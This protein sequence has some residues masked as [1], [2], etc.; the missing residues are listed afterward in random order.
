MSIKK[1]LQA[2]IAFEAIVIKVTINTSRVDR[3]VAWEACTHYYDDDD[4][5]TRLCTCV[6]C[7]KEHMAGRRQS[8][9]R[10]RDTT[11]P[12]E[13]EKHLNPMQSRRGANPKFEEPLPNFC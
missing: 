1:T 13:W 5:D 6:A 2:S 8:W 3:T 9:P 7:V 10:D 11:T 4:D 12:W